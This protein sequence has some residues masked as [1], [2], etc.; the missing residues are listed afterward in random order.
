MGKYYQDSE[1]KV[2]DTLRE[3]V[4]DLVTTAKN[5][6]KTTWFLAV[7]NDTMEIDGHANVEHWYVRN[8]PDK[9]SDEVNVRVEFYLYPNDIKERFSQLQNAGLYTVDGR[10]CKID[11]GDDVDMITYLFSEF[12]RKAWNY[13]G[14]ERFW[15][16][17]EA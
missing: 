11:C 14:E 12:V 15:I 3:A 7:E 13:D 8:I 4:E 9:K 10:Y 2:L 6:P 16:L 1:V 5:N 17:D